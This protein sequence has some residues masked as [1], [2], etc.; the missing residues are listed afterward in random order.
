[1][2]EVLKRPNDMFAFVKLFAPLSIPWYGGIGG[3]FGY[4]VDRL[5]KPKYSDLMIV[6]KDEW[7]ISK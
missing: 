2:V 7:M 4:I 5:S 1:M 6:G 3:L